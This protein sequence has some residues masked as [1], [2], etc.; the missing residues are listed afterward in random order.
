MAEDIFERK[1]R[2]LGGINL[3]VLREDVD[4]LIAN[5][6]GPGGGVTDHGLLTGLADDDHTQYHNNTRG[7][8]R[9]YQKSEVDSQLAS[10]QASDADL[11]AIAGLSP[12]NDDVLQRKSGAWTNRTVAQLKTDLALSN[13]DNTS[14]ANKPISTATQTALDLKLDKSVAAAK[15][16]ILV[17]TANDTISVLTAGSNGKILSAN[18]AETTGLEWIDA[19]SGG[20]GLK[21]R[22]TTGLLTSGG[23]APFGP[24][25]ASGTWTMCPAAWRVTVPAVA[26]DV[27]QWTPAVIIGAATGDAEL[28]LASIVSG[29]PAR[30]ASSQTSTQSANGHGGLYVWYQSGRRL[31]TPMT[32]VVTADDIDGGNVTIALMYRASGSG[33]TIGVSAYPSQIDLVNL[34]TPSS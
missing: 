19:P 22:G 17:A 10:K 8:A 6:G 15:G 4:E 34:G 32:W 14:D 28:D 7:D 21:S 25:G 33:I 1:A 24:A 13:V 11:T 18:S 26:G 2:E 12:S 16:D 20:G 27:L 9:Y 29:A 30:Y 31:G 23:G 3:E 5:P